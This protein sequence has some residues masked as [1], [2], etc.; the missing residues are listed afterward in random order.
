MSSTLH[1]FTIPA[2]AADEQQAALNQFLTRHRVVAVE[3]HWL[4]VGTDSH[5]VICV[6]VADGPGPLPSALK[7]PYAK[8]A[9][10]GR[11]DRVDYREVLSQDDFALFAILRDLRQ[12]MSAAESVPP[13][14][15]FTNEQLAAIAQRRPVDID[16]MRNIEGVGAARIGKY[17]E[18]FLNAL[19]C[20]TIGTLRQ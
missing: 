3:K 9:K 19:R 15:L 5:W 17:G 7:L 11:G 2:F 14:V 6:T 20:Y 8:G 13:Y 12:T 16:A 1:F 4:A 18:A 10:G